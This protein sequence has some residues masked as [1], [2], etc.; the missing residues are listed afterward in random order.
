MLIS[1]LGFSYLRNQVIF[2]KFIHAKN[3]DQHR[4]NV[5]KEVIIVQLW[6]VSHFNLN[7]QGDT[8]TKVTIQNKLYKPVDNTW[9]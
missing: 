2:K 9:P 3:S 4:F 1:M 6:N 7:S 5:L 8:S